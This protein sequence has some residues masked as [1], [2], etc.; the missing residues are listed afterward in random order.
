V[1]RHDLRHGV[2]LIGGELVEASG[3]TLVLCQPAAAILVEDAEAVLRVGLPLFDGEFV[4]A[5]GFP[6]VLRQPAAA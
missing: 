6:L 5:S 4:E 1:L 3:F 2:P